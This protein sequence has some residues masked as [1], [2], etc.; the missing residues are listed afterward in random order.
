[1]S[2][3]F[4]KLF[5]S[6]TESTIWCE[7]SDTRVVWITL[8]AMSDKYGRVWGSIPGI[9]KRAAVSLEAT[10]IALSKFLGP[11]KYSRSNTYDPDSN[12]RRI[13]AIEGGW[14][15]INHAH[16]RRIRDEEERRAYKA[17]HER[18]RREKK[19]GQSR[20]QSGQ[21]WTSVDRGGHNAEAEADTYIQS[22]KGGGGSSNGNGKIPPPP[23]FSQ[24]DFDERDY[25]AFCKAGKEI[26]SK[27][28]NGWGQN[29]TDEQLF[30]HQCIAAAVPTKKMREVLERLGK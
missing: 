12:G 7:D 29:L 14:K 27:L 28:A 11:D 19:R 21:K 13:E 3:T 1:M 24:S 18:K 30:E 23:N 8:L 2:V 5:S 16:Y 9:A 25:R 26:Q 17:E 15:I 10:E 22:S 20:G 6:I 4:T